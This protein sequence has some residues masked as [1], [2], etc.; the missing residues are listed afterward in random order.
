ML[1]TDTAGPFEAQLGIVNRTR[2]P[3]SCLTAAPV[4][5]ECIADGVSEGACICPLKAPA[6]AGVL[7]WVVRVHSVPQA[8][9]LQQ[10][11][12]S[13]VGTLGLGDKWLGPLCASP[14]AQLHPAERI[15]LQREFCKQMGPR[16]LCVTLQCLQEERL[17]PSDNAQPLPGTCP[18]HNRHSVTGHRYAHSW[19]PEHCP[20]SLTECTTG[21]VP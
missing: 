5:V 14:L 2:P 1:Q 12:Q 10:G 17:H 11:G 13:L 16:G 3:Q 18:M 19:D 7:I 4:S 15:R 20:P 8:P 21:T 9:N 6:C